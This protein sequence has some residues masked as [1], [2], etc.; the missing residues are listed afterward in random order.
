[1][2]KVSKKSMRGAI[3][4]SYQLIYSDGKESWEMSKESILNFLSPVLQIFVLLC[5]TSLVSA[6]STNKNIPS[7]NKT[8]IS[9]P[10]IIAK[11]SVG[12]FPQSVT[13]NKSNNRIYAANDE[14]GTVSVIDG[15]SDIVLTTI[16]VGS[17]P[18]S[19]PNY[20]AIDEEA[21]KIYVANS[22]DGTISIIDGKTN[23]VIGP[24]IIVGKAALPL[25]CVNT[26]T[27]QGSDSYSIILNH[28]TKKIYV[29]NFADSTIVVVDA[30]TKKVIGQ[31]IP[32]N[33]VP[34]ILAVNEKTN[35][36]YVANY[37]DATVQVLDGKS[38]QVVKTI[39]VGSPSTPDGC[40]ETF[41][42]S[43][44]GS[45]PTSV[46]VNEKTNKIYLTNLR[47]GTVLAINGETDTV[48]GSPIKVGFGVFFTAVDEE[49]NVIYAVNQ[50]SS[51][52]SVI[53]GKT[54]HVIGSP[55]SLGTG[56]TPAG[57]DPF[58]G[59]CTGFPSAPTGVT[60]NHD[61]GKVYVS[62]GVLENVTVLAYPREMGR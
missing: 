27:N 55:I 36:I 9:L 52:L 11:I 23:N 24:P 10:K 43:D 39:V 42:C 33:D 26:C 34:Y 8:K 14:G 22:G 46:S 60:L 61:T 4:L 5:T 48:V 29:G 28:K 35:K 49:A 53:D 2:S 16:P 31:P 30:R 25:G 13:L 41:T 45:L 17:G 1:M 44:W 20:L 58:A 21:N 12:A 51:S 59:S 3:V 50:F 57:C 19:E 56:F 18:G 37:Y 40:Y 62:D 54:D 6:D 38:D 47:D 7:E 32:V 15:K